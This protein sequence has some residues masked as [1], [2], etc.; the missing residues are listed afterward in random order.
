MGDKIRRILYG[1]NSKYVLSIILG[2]GLASL[3][4][5]AC[6][7]RNCLIFKGAPISKIKDQIFKYNNKCY[8]FKEDTTSCNYNKKIVEFA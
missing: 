6:N 3:F 1:K 4:R 2:I 7:N 8:K 5:K